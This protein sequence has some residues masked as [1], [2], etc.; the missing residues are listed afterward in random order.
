[1]M[2]T[3]KQNGNSSEQKSTI[4]QLREILDK[5]SIETQ[6]MTYEQLKKYVEEQLSNT[7]HPTRVWR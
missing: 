3:N 5:I 6:D 7:L 4:D 1:M 2:E